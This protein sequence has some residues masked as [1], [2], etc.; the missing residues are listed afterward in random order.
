MAEGATGD[1]TV[2]VV[3]PCRNRSAQLRDS[4][5]SVLAQ[6]RPP[7]EVVVVD[8]ASHEDL[9]RALADVPTGATRLRVLRQDRPRGANAARNSGVAAATGELVA[10][11]DSDDLWL[12]DKLERQLA[13]F[14]SAGRP[15]NALVY[16]DFLRM[17]IDGTTVRASSIDLDEDERHALLVDNVINTP[18]VLLVR[19]HFLRFGFDETLPR[20]QDWDAW[21]SMLDE[22]VFLHVEEVLV[23]AHESPDSLTRDARGYRQA[24][25]L[26]AGKHRRLFA[27][28]PRLDALMARRC[29][30]AARKDSR[31]P[32]VLSWS[33][34]YLAAELR[35]RRAR[36]GAVGTG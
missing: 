6:T 36:R 14:D 28:D 26:I 21:L 5:R 7:D 4:V 16:C 12:P 31:Y 15:G 29:I 17:K 23:H 19:E 3:V 9:A 10:F 2:S 18:T 34:R 27:R 22:T 25:L 11:Q 30:G 33:A 24:L 13:A 32:A 35:H 20:L 8:D 1:V